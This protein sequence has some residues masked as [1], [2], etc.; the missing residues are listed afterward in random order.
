MSVPR[1]SRAILDSDGLDDDVRAAL[2]VI[3]EYLH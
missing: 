3:A 2:A 1:S